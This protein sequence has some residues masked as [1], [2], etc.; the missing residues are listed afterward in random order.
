MN[1][2]LRLWHESD[3]L[4]ERPDYEAA[5]TARL[6]SDRHANGGL[7][8]WCSYMSNPGRH[9]PYNGR[10]FGDNLYMVVAHVEDA[11]LYRM[12]LRELQLISRRFDENPESARRE[13][14][15]MLAAGVKVI[16]IIEGDDSEQQVIILD[17]RLIVVFRRTERAV[18]A[19]EQ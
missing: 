18:P 3:A 4:F 15:R 16:S 11:H 17:Y 5:L 2:V 7:G 6:Q 9:N 1:H 12:T 13:R 14:D 8:L 19:P 10:V